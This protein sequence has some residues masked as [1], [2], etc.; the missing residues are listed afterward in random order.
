MINSTV[1][2]SFLQE[3]NAIEGVYDDDSLE[4]SIKAWSYLKDIGKL[5]LKK[6]LITH[7]ICM[8]KHLPKDRGIFRTQDV[9]IAGHLGA[10]VC[11]L[12]KLMTNW[13]KKAN[14]NRNEQ[15]IQRDHV[16]F[17]QIHPFIDGNGR[18]G[19]M[20][21]NW[22]RLRNNLDILVIKEEER[23]EYYQWFK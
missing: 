3:S 7:R 9:F 10:P 21:M 22:Q 14:N 11:R 19:R 20:L 1:E 8:W 6:I 5:T 12:N 13:L 16:M 15:Q 18:I 17:E 4:R 23:Q 2:V